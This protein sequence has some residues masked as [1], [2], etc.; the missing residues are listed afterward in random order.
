MPKK[1]QEKVATTS[2]PIANENLEKLRKVFPQFV[3]D[4]EIDFNA[5]QTFFDKEDILVGEEKYGLN[6]AGKSNA[7]KAIRLPATGTLTPQPKESK[8]F[9]KTENLFIEGDNLEVLKLLQKNYR[10]SIKMIYIDPPYNT[11]KDFIYKDNFTENKS[12]YYERTGQTKGGI[13]MTTNTES[14][15]GRAHV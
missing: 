10:D 3:K 13:K 12:D 1:K 6:W 7:F 8:D 2:E 11:G 15:I 5:L 9:D 4:G 14:K